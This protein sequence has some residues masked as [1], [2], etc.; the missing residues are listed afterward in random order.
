VNWADVAVLFVVLVLTVKGFARGFVRE[1]GGM[2]AILAGCLAALYYNGVLDDWLEF[3]RL[4]AWTAHAVGMVL[5]AV[6]VYIAFAIAFGILRRIAKLP[7]I[8]T[9]NALAGAVVGFA[10]GVAALWIVLF[11]ALLFPLTTEARGDMKRSHF[12]P[13]LVSEERSAGEAVFGV[14]P[15]IAR[16][17]VR[18]MLDRQQL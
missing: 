12:V 3:F 14:L 7:G 6:V 1:I 10:K 11:V 2:V 16:P 18:P 13:L 5:C 4:N 8:G 9:L 15:G 17:Y